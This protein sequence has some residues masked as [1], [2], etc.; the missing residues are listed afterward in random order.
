LLENLSI[1]LST[2]IQDRQVKEFLTYDP[3][4]DSWSTVEIKEEV[5]SLPSFKRSIVFKVVFEN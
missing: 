4:N 3:W 2:I 1:D 5:F